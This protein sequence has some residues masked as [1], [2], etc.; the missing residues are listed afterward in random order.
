MSCTFLC[1]LEKCSAIERHSVNV[2]VSIF[3]RHR[4]PVQVIVGGG[5]GVVTSRRDVVVGVA[6]VAV[7]ATVVA[8]AD[9]AQENVLKLDE[10]VLRVEGPVLPRTETVAH[11]LQ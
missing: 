10:E 11:S 8:T 9:Q 7:T 5:S 3:V 1:V 2:A 4:L 6:T